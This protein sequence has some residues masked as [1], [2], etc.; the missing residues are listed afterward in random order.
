M[1]FDFGSFT[2]QSADAADYDALRPK[3]L[4][5]SRIS[6]VTRG[7][8]SQPIYATCEDAAGNSHSVVLKLRDPATDTNTNPGHLCI[9]RD[10]VGSILARRFGLIVPDYAIVTIS[11]AFARMAERGPYGPRIRRNVGVHFGSMRID[12]ATHFVGQAV[13]D[14]PADAWEPI[15]CFDAMA[16]NGDRMTSNPNAMWNGMQLYAID[17]GMIAP[18]WQTA[19]NLT[20]GTLFDPL[21]VRLHASASSLRSSG[22][23]FNKVA[24][25]QDSVDA[26]FLA[27]LRQQIPQEW[28]DTEE[29]SALLNFLAA[30][31]SIQ[32]P[33]Q[34]VLKEACV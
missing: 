3:V 18:L 28:A 27:W 10:L 2:R 33:Q 25:W 16:Y 29:I 20:T 14:A 23:T 5:V 11:E 9:L 34:H 15:L 7:G 6:G 19:L 4:R 12:S 22:R 32:G 1:S 17:H 8:A 30:R 24:E 26:P 21:A 13:I 31:V